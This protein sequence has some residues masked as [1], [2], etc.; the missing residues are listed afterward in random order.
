[1]LINAPPPCRVATGS[2]DLSTFEP[3]AVSMVLLQQLNQLSSSVGGLLPRQLLSEDAPLLTSCDELT[4]HLSPPWT[5]IWPVLSQHI[6]LLVAHGNS[7]TE[8]SA[9]LAPVLVAGGNPT[10]TE[11]ACL[12]LISIFKNSPGME[13]ESLSLSE[14]MTSERSMVENVKEHV[15]KGKLACC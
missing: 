8:V 10:H 5:R 6:E 14:D 15:R 9:T 11:K 12:Q 2:K 1:M 13:G 3:G 7:F 4:G